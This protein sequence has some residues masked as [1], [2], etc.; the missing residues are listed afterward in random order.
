ME[1][2]RP[3]TSHLK[4]KVPISQQSLKTYTNATLKL[5]NATNNRIRDEIKQATTNE[6]QQAINDASTAQ[7]DW[8]H[9]YTPAQRA[10]ILQNSS[11]IMK[12][13]ADEIIHH[14]VKDT[15]RTI[16]EI[17]SYDLPS[18]VRCLSYY[19]HMPSIIS[20]GTYHDIDHSFA[21]VK[22][23][24]IPI[25]VGIGAW[26]YPLMNA[27]AKSAPALSFGNAMIFKPSEL[28]PNSALIL[29][30]IYEQAGV[31]PGLFQVLLGDGLVGEQLVKSPTV[32]KISFTGSL[33][34]GRKI[35]QTASL[36]SHFP[37]LTLELGGKS[38]LIIMDD[39]DID[40]SVDGAIL[41]NFYSNG[42]VCSNGTRVFVHE[43]LK[44]EF[45]D[46]LVQKTK[47]MKIGDP[48]HEDTEIGP[49]VSETHLERVL[50]YIDIG[51]NVDR[52]TLLY[53][54]DIIESD[55]L[56]AGFYLSPA[57]FTDCT[58]EMRIVQEEVFGMLMSVLTFKDEEEVIRRANATQYGLAAG[59][60][61]NNIKRGHRMANS[62]HAGN[63]WINNYNVGHVELPW[64]GH[65]QS[66]IG[67]ENG[68]YQS[69]H[70]WTK[71]KS[72]YVEIGNS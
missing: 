63:I 68:S 7:K 34:I 25:T 72:V 23:E 65:K 61:T 42:Q 69:A 28:T 43:S 62:L 59:I 66:G 44:D 70:E 11:F 45:L 47:E 32:G 52:A 54:G 64:G 26:N 46:K 1:K 39:A 33:Q 16:S 4:S 67:M 48:F 60:Y 9:N 17:K 14:E 51:K 30:D 24:P 31:P 27:I 57:I 71:S 8:Y 49:M 56:E 2:L 36:S 10:D 12:Q 22:R 5:Y 19:A 13:R 37:T 40:Q 15:S 55:N 38:P 21:Y 58:D 3:L 53:G 20:N 6:I 29:A 41:A 50:D 18:A 35:N